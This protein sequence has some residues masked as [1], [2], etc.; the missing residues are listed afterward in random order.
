MRFDTEP[1]M[2]RCYLIMV[3]ILNGFN[4][5]SICVAIYRVP[6]IIFLPPPQNLNRSFDFYEQ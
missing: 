5:I 3:F 6:R 2:R 4:L 1:L